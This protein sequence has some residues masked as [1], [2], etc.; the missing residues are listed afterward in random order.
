VFINPVV[1]GQAATAFLR[2][3]LVELLHQKR[4]VWLKQNFFY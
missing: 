1:K 4:G 2:Q 3:V